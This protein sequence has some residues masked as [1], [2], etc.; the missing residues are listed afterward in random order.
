MKILLINSSLIKRI[1]PTQFSKEPKQLE[2]FCNLGEAQKKLPV[3]MFQLF[4]RS[5]FSQPTRSL[6]TKLC[7]W[8]IPLLEVSYYSYHGATSTEFLLFSSYRGLEGAFLFGDAYKVSFF[9]R[10]QCLYESAWLFR[11]SCSTLD[12]PIISQ[13]S[14]DLKRLKLLFLTCQEELASVQPLLFTA[15]VEAKG[16]GP[17]PAR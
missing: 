16:T 13:I 10:E 11:S 17:S 1:L 12:A 14:K 9:R 5:S 3:H 4:T 15:L 2:R 6:Y 8:N 7:S